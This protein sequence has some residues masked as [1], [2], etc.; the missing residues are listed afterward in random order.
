MAAVIHNA[1]VILMR[2]I[3]ILLIIIAGSTFIP[4]RK[5]KDEDKE[6][7]SALYKER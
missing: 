3:I 6:G 4:E 1:I 2:I 7:N 5:H